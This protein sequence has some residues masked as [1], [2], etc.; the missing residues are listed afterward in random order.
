MAATEPGERGNPGADGAK[1]R[2]ERPPSDRYA[3]TGSAS[4]QSPSTAGPSGR[5][6]L[7]LPAV[8]A[9]VAAL[10]G[11]TGLYAVGALIASTA[12][13]LFVAGLTGAAV[14]LILARAAVPGDLAAPALTRRQ[15]TWLAI[16]LSIGA[17]AAGAV[18]TWLNAIGEGGTLGFID[19]Q[20]ET[21]GPFIVGEAVI[22]T[23]A[24]AWGASAGPVEG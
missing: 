21:F 1:G 14:G 9:A 4:T 5:G 20:L 6:R 11:A 24:A 15:V 23:L 13:L 3:N 18:A 16:A 10:I 19:Y 8:K 17:I 12:G 22:A 2:L 7:P